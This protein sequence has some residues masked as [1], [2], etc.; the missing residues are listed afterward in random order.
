MG[1]DALQRG[2]SR[3]YNDPSGFVNPTE[4]NVPLFLFVALRFNLKRNS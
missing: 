1:M 2:L 4:S 3:K